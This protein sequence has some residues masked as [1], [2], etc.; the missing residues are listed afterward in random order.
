MLIFGFVVALVVG[1]GLLVA[2]LVDMARADRRAAVQLRGPM[3]GG[4]PP[5]WTVAALRQREHAES[6]PM[7]PAPPRGG[8]RPAQGVATG[9]HHAGG[10]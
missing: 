10:A 8:R 5:R 6:M 4:G 9:H 7:Y 3:P 2:L 1:L